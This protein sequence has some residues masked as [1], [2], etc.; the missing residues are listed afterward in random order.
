MLGAERATEAGQGRRDEAAFVPR[1]A[2]VG[3][4]G[5]GA[6]GPEPRRAIGRVG[7]QPLRQG[8]QMQRAGLLGVAGSAADAIE[9]PQMYDAGERRAGPARGGEQ[10]VERRPGIDAQLEA[11]LVDPPGA[12]A[13]AD[14]EAAV[15]PRLERGSQRIADPAA[16]GEDQ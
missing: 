15:A 10:P 7:D 4:P 3:L 14:D 12:R 8:Q 9:A 2:A 16:I 11:T 1:R 6:A 5:A 13:G